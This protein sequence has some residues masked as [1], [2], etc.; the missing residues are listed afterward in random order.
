MRYPGAQG[1]MPRA[2]RGALAEIRIQDLGGR[3]IT[4]VPVHMCFGIDVFWVF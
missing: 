3:L 4:Y 2:S 1:S